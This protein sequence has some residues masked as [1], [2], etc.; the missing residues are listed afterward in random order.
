MKTS[1]RCVSLPFR[2][3]SSTVTWWTVSWSRRTRPVLAQNCEVFWRGSSESPSGCLSA[4]FGPNHTTSRHTLFHKNFT[5]R[6]P[7]PAL[8][9]SQW[10]DAPPLSAGQP[11]LNLLYMCWAIRGRSASH[12]GGARGRDCCQRNTSVLQ[13]VGS[14]P[15]SHSV[16]SS[17][18]HNIVLSYL[19]RCGF[20]FT[21]WLQRQ[22]WK[23]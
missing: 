13:Q 9:L 15:K 11:L 8:V 14:L 7:N 22:G 23:L 20:E 3:I 21:Y 6:S 5:V 19:F 2:S 17:N 12:K 16:T 10:A 1:R 4:G 18:N